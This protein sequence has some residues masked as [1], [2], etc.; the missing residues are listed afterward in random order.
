MTLLYEIFPVFL[1][2]ICFKLYDIYVATQVGIVATF[3][4]VVFNRIM[5]KA[6]DKKQVV[7]LIV[8]VAFGSLTLYFHNPIFVKWKPTIVFWIFS[9]VIFVTQLFT[10]KPMMQRLMENVLQAKEQVPQRVWL[11]LNTAWGFC[12]IVIGC[13]NLYIAY[14]YSNEAWVNFKFYGITGALIG[15]SVIQ[16]LYLFR[17]VESVG[18]DEKSKIEEKE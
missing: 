8:F 10:A 7:T 16:T 9:L 15:L 12:F 1:F 13:V 3:A 11:Q 2:F 4:Q 18:K 17:Y 6:W 5:F 14:Y